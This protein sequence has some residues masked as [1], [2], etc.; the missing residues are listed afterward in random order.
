[1]RTAQAPQRTYNEPLGSTDT[2][3]QWRQLTVRQSVAAPPIQLTLPNFSGPSVETNMGRAGWLSK[4]TLG[5]R[6][7]LVT[8]GTAAGTWNTYPEPPF[9]LLGYI[10]VHTNTQS[11]LVS[12]SSRMLSRWQASRRRNTFPIAQEY[13]PAYGAVNPKFA[14]PVSLAGVPT[15]G[16]AVG[17]ALAAST[18]YYIAG[19]LEIPI[20]TDDA[21]FLGAQYLQSDRITLTVQI[22]PP[23]LTDI[24]TFSAGGFA[25]AVVTIIP[26][27]EF[28]SQPSDQSIHP[29]NEFVHYLREQKKVISASGANQW[30]L[31]I[32]NTYLSI[33]GFLEN[34]GVPAV[35]TNPAAPPTNLPPF[36][37]VGINYAQTMNPIVE[38]YQIHLDYLE[39]MYGIVLPD[40]CF[41]FDQRL[42][43]GIPGFYEGR[44]FINSAL[45]S[46]LQVNAN[47][48]PM[49]LTGPSLYLLTEQL[50]RIGR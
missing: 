50:Q 31:D 12:A 25:S 1:M 33:L 4:I 8:N 46:D 27:A 6:A 37:Q 11:D 41:M 5:F 35:Y 14:K 20:A 9:N 13:D 2:S 36:S 16:S 17:S 26:Q 44:D 40:A 22:T 39:K 29:N 10:R 15:A 19:N 38:D 7:T 24:A 18:T 28:F 34:N 32:G 23:A 3:L 43:A 49:T 47:I 42:G 30:P 21:L 48:N 45:T